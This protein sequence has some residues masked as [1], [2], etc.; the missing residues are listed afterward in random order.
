MIKLWCPIILLIFITTICVI[1]YQ[2]GYQKGLIKQDYS[3]LTITND[4]SPLEIRMLPMG[5]GKYNIIRC[6]AWTI[7]LSN[8]TLVCEQ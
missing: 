7:F 8:N 5:M 1:T 2:K 4:S 6:P 3:R